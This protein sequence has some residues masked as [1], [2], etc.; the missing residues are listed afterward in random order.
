MTSPARLTR[1]SSKWM[2]A[3]T[4][5]RSLA[6]RCGWRPRTTGTP[7]P[8][9]SPSISSCSS[10]GTVTASRKRPSDGSG[11]RRQHPLPARPR[12][13]PSRLGPPR[14][15]HPPAPAPPSQ[16]GGATLRNREADHRLPRVAIRAIRPRLSATAQAAVVGERMPQDCGTGTGAVL[17]AQSPAT[18][19]YSIRTR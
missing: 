9:S 13:P 8:F 1:C 5:C 17:R 15:P 14:R 3:I 12:R 7:T 10:A 2:A 4:A 6:P 18:P 16:P 19:S 11:L